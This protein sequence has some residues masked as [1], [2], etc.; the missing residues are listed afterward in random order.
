MKIV[1]IGNRNTLQRF[2]PFKKLFENMKD[3]QIH[4]LTEEELKGMCEPALAH[5]SENSE[6]MPSHEVQKVLLEPNQ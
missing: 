5:L 3:D 2:S 1:L 6:N 4:Q